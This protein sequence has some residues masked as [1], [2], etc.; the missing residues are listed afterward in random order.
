MATISI[1]LAL[2]CSLMRSMC[3]SDDCVLE[4]DFV[5]DVAGAAAD[6][7]ARTLSRFPLCDCGYP[8]AD[9]FTAVDLP[10]AGSLGDRML[11]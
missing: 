9:D 10:I 3:D 4:F 8:G 1:A 6:F 5:G 7:Y 11:H 2:R